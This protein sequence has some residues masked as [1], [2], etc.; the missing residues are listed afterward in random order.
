[1]PG[2]WPA[3]F[4]AC[5]TP[6]VCASPGTTG[7]RVCGLGAG[8]FFLPCPFNLP[9]VAYSSLPEVRTGYLTAH[10]L[11]SKSPWPRRRGRLF[12]RLAAAPWSYPP[13]PQLAPLLPA[14]LEED[15]R[16]QV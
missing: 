16:A 5:S 1:M 9:I 14:P 3:R 12:Y 13:W 2:T 6:R 11:C 15:G 4:R 8:R 7:G 10:S